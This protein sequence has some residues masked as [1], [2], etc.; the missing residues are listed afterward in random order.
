LSFQRWALQKNIDEQIERIRFEL[1]RE[2][3][4]LDSGYSEAEV[5]EVV[6]MRPI[7]NCKNWS[8]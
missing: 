6:D 1:I 7:L 4:L 5:N 2:Y 3:K 8:G